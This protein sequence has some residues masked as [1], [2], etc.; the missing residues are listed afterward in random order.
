MKTVIIGAGALGSIIAALLARSGA[1][2][3]LVARGRRADLLEREGVRVTGLD[4]LTQPVAIARPDGQALEA[5][6]VIVCVK[7]FDTLDAL[8]GVRFTGAPV[9][10]SLQNGVRKNQL[11]ASVF[12]KSNVLGA[13]ASVAGEVMPDGGVR[14]T[15]NAALPLGELDGGVS[16]RARLVARTLRKAGLAA[17]ATANI[18]SVEWTKYASFLP[19]MGVSLLTRLPTGE[20][21]SDP[22]VARVAAAII[23][24]AGALARVSGVTL[25]DGG[26]LPLAT[27]ATAP[28]D[29]A[30]RLVQQFGAV[31]RQQAPAHR[32]S[33]LQ[34]LLRGGR[35]EVDDLLGHASRLGGKLGVPTPAI[36]ICFRLCVALDRKAVEAR[37]A[38]GGAAPEPAA[39]PAA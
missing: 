3:T 1:E 37:A 4:E 21:L 14:Y 17:E 25:A 30:T 24:E 31:M 39:S 20:A 19:L 32:V 18:R 34:D 16:A 35:L 33:A 11:L 6:L 29:E 38:G 7:T 13:A 2:V 36:D 9:A 27:I 23:A 15:M 12:G 22:D 8:Q 28:P 5:D 26:P 10:M